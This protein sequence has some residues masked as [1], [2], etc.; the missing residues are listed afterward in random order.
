M[1]WAIDSA[2]MALPI[3][4]IGYYLKQSNM[5]ENV[6]NILIEVILFIILFI[7]LYFINHIQ[8]SVNMNLRNFGHYPYLYY[9]G[10]LVGLFMFIFFSKQFNKYD[11]NIVKTISSGSIVIMGLHCATFL[12]TVTIIKKTVT[13]LSENQPLLHGA[14][15]LVLISI[16][17]MIILYYPIILLQKFFSFFWRQKA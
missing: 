6:N 3:F 2:F 11:F 9:V 7:V 17:T 15:L 1:F 8:G 4:M 10:A 16:L 13:D 14:L 5:L 12:Y